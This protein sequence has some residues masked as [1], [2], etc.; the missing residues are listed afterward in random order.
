MKSVARSLLSA[1]LAFCAGA[2]WADD[3][4][5][6][7]D[8]PIT[9]VVPWAAGGS[10]DQVTR[11]LAGELEEALDQKVVVVNQ[12]G[13]SGSIGKKN[14]W[15]APHD[16]Y[17]WAAGSPKMLGTY[18]L[19]GLFDTEIED[20]RAYL[21]VVTPTLVGVNPDT[22]YQTMG[23]L[24]KAMA[25]RPGQVSVATAGV[26][27][28]GHTAIEA[29]AQA[30]GL[31]YKHISYDGGNP[32]VIATVAGETEVTTQLSVEQ[33][34]MARAGRLRILAVVANEAVALAGLGTLESITKWTGPLPDTRTHFGIFAPADLPPEVIETFDM[35][36][37]QRI[38]TSQA[39]RDYADE[40]GTVMTTEY[41]DAAFDVVQPTIQADAWSLYAAGRTIASP[42]DFGIPKP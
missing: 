39:I 19:V 25:E 30:T 2:A 24:L 18:K 14:V 11:I 1:L 34:E 7:P 12:P 20:W 3:Y 37:E 40:R 28:S 42:E 26:G 21:D 27:S 10:T 13:A 22:P 9:I 23:D 16:G 17:T 35:I 41:G 33:I 38:K 6:R 5:W 8:K 15:R 32:A 4:P 36:W 29:I 31:T